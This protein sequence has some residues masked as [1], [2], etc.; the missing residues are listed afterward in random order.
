MK[1][2]KSSKASLGD[3]ARAAG[4]SKTATGYALR[5][6]PSVSKKTRERVV[7]IASE[8][9][10]VPDARMAFRMTKVRGTKRKDLLPIAW[11][12]TDAERDAWQKHLFLSPYLEG[13]QE[14]CLQLGYRIEEIWTKQPGMTMRRLS[15]ILF[16]R[17]IEGVIVPHP[18]KH[19]RLNWDHLAGVSLEGSLIA[20]RLHRVMT[21]FFFNLQLALKA[22]KRYGYR[23]IAICLE[24]AIDRHTN[25]TIRAAVHYFFSTTPKAE[26]ITPLFY[27]WGKDSM[28]DAG[29]HQ[30]RAWI[31]KHWKQ[32]PDVLVGHSFNIMKWA[33]SAGYRVPEE[34][35]I[36]HIATDDDVREWTGISSN[37]REIGAIAAAHVIALIQNRQF[38]LPKVAVDTLVRGSWSPGDTLLKLK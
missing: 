34:I 31:K 11:L 35:G 2:K 1:T 6:Y 25:H 26:R 33:Q 27:T 18:V 8:L 21:D 7:R 30:V 17:G 13:A 16:Q 14:R 15:Q 29:E 4:I 28:A 3:V 12:N 19:I 32:K 22:V 24:E 5:N 10:Y 37:R 38:G 36:V 23:R 20:P 9:G